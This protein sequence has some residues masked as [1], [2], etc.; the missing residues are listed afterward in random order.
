MAR[1][2]RG[3]D[4][5]DGRGGGVTVAAGKLWE[6]VV[7]R[8]KSQFFGHGCGVLLPDRNLAAGN[9][10]RGAG[11]DFADDDHAG[12]AVNNARV[13]AA[14][15]TEDGDDAPELLLRVFVIVTGLKRKDPGSAR[16]S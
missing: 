2:L 7:G 3:L 16:R 9:Q 6:L 5:H 15:F 13:A 8:K 14:D 11:A 10:D 4:T 12:P 1:G